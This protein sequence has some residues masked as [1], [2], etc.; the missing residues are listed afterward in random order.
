MY[1]YDSFQIWRRLVRP[2][3]LGVHFDLGLRAFDGRDLKRVTQNRIAIAM[4]PEA[5]VQSL[6]HLSLLWR[7]HWLAG[8]QD[9]AVVVGRQLVERFPEDP[10]GSLELAQMLTDAGRPDEAS[11]ILLAGVE[12]HPGD[13]DLWFELGLA[14]ERAENEAL[15]LKAFQEVWRLEHDQEPQDR[16]F[17]SEEAFLRVVE[18]TMEE[19][20]DHIRDA[21]GNVAVIIEDYPDRWVVDEGIADPRILGLFMGPDKPFEG[22]VEAVSDGPA[23]VYLYRWNIERQCPTLEEVEREI[24]ITVLHE[25]GHYLGLDEE[26]L[27]A[28]GLS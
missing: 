6:E 1:L 3:A 9:E 15:R 21:I 22:S 17:L 28:R 14:A 13:S 26:D 4:L 23:R 8:R 18:E 19:L 10:D 11:V 24:R 2:D 25:I 5:G 27:E 7:E 20:P 12:K 16:L